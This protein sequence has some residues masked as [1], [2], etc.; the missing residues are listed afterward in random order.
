MVL[1]CM[2][3]FAGDNYAAITSGADFRFYKT[4]YFGYDIP[5]NAEVSLFIKE[6]SSLGTMFTV[7]TR[8]PYSTSDTLVNL[9]VGAVYKYEVTDKIKIL[10]SLSFMTEYTQY[11]SFIFGLIGAM[12]GS[13][14][15]TEGIS[16]MGGASLTWIINQEPVYYLTPIAGVSVSF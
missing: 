13:F 4:S 5:L 15:I 1:S 7:G 12:K 14:H 6:D 16:L 3:L 2:G 8:F 10:T 11:K 9:S